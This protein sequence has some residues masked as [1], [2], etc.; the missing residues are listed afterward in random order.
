MKKIKEILFFSRGDSNIASTWSNVPYLFTKHLE[1]KGITV[2]RINIESHTLFNKLLEKI[3]NH[4]IFKFLNLKFKGIHYQY[5]RSFHSN[6]VS[7]S[8]IKKEITKYPKADFCI[9]IGYEYINKFNSIPSMLFGDWTLEILIKER[10]NREPFFIE[11]KLIENENNNINSAAIVVSLFSQCKESM[12]RINPLANIVA[13]DKNVINNLYE[14]T[15]EKESILELKNQAKNIL[16]IGR[17]NYLEGAKLLVKSFHELYKEDRSLQ[18]HIIGLTQKHFESL[19]IDNVC[20]HGFLRKDVE[21]E[22]NLYYDLLLKAKVVI[23]PTPI[24]GG[25]SSI[26]ESMFFYTPIIISPFKE[27]VSEFGQDIN[28]G[29]Y[30]KHF[31]A[32]S[33]ISSI[34]EII[35]LPY[36]KYK[37]MAMNAHKS[38]ES[39][40]WDSYVNKIINSMEECI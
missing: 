9:F 8:I 33:L 15:I 28:F 5:L 25:Y 2:R 20:F 18:L 4:L 21:E 35:F 3:W 17:E 36:E 22:K 27:F 14:G 6:K 38:V 12:K 29:I 1:E 16:F 39:Y 30:N 40:T 10:E 19:P 11:K 37:L 13:Y 34:K 31:D 23:N 24:W 26:I 7:Y 32:K